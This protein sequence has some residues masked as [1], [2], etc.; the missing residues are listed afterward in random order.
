MK[1]ISH[2]GIAGL[3][4]TVLVAAACTPAVPEMVLSVDLSSHGADI[5]SSLY[6]VFFE[7]INHAGDG[8]LYGELLRNRSFEDGTVPAGYAVRDGRLWSPQAVNYGTGRLT[9]RDYPWDSSECPGWSIEGGD[10]TAEVT[11]DDPN[12]AAAPASLRVSAKAPL[13]LLNGG[14]WGIRYDKGGAYRLRMFVKSDAPGLSVSLLD[15][16]G[17]VCGSGGIELVPDGEWH[18]YEARV[19]SSEDA[20]KGSFRIDLQA[21]EYRFDYVS[22]FPEDTFR[23]RENGLRKDVAQ[24]VEALRPA[25]V[26]WPGGCVVEGITLGNRFD[27]KKTL[28][29]PESRPGEYDTWGYR[30]S[31]GFGYKEFL[32]FCEDLGA[33]A[34]FVC[35]VGLACTGR[36]GE[37]CADEDLHIYVED[38]LDAVEYALGD[39]LSRWGALR[40]AQGHPEPYPLR[41][42]EIGNENF[43][44]MYDSRYNIFYDAIKSRWPDLTLIS[45]YGLDPSPDARRVEMVDPHWYVKPEEFFGHPDRFDDYDRNAPRI[46]VGEYSCNDGVGSGNM[47]AALSEAAFLTAV[48]R[49]ADVV[50]MAS[51]APLFEHENDRSWPVNLIRI[52]SDK[53]VGRSSY[54]VQKMFAQNRPSYNLL[55]DAV[56][57]EETDREAFML[58]PGS[59][60]LGTCG[61]SA[62][63]SDVTLNGQPLADTDFTRVS[64]SRRNAVLASDRRIF[65]SDVL[66]FRVNAA[67]DELFRVFFDL[68]SLTLEEGGRYLAFGCAGVSLNGFY[69]ENSQW[70]LVPE[71]P[72]APVSAGEWHSVRVEFLQDGVNC[73]VDGAPAFSHRTAIVNRR[74]FA[75]GYDAASSEVVLKLVNASPRPCPACIEFRNGTVGRDGRVITLSAPSAEAENSFDAQDLISPGERRFRF[76]AGSPL[77]LEPNSLTIIRL[78]ASAAARDPHAN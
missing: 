4:L 36:T 68:K 39:T 32:D 45:N 37:F 60:G 51:Y 44:P 73:T 20:A 27:W 74:F 9:S 1:R 26:R 77:I 55:T 8:G 70:N 5:P 61:S 72:C 33:D 6:G 65:T 62:E 2:S 59:F 46:Y 24:M 52:S 78:P 69:G 31:Y 29:D 19:V 63:F 13:T 57:A 38:A 48:E 76:K 50:R 43:G 11:T 7:E 67:G 49:N 35:N 28:G 21:G 53:V 42:V 15:D 3:A 25:F 71:Q 47:F 34:M 10:F 54:H 17:R 40:A 66:E 14:F 30:N 12:F 23:G 22:L 75:A 16:C 64:D 41:Y 56:I 58:E 18:E